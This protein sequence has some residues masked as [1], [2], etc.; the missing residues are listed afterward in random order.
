MPRYSKT[1]IKRLNTCHKDLQI[2]FYEVI[3]GFDCTILCGTRYEAEQNR[4]FG[5]G[6]SKTLYPNSKHNKIPALAVDACPSPIPAW[7]DIKSFSYFGGWVMS[8]AEKL[9]IGLR[10]GGD[11]DHD[12]N[13]NDQ[14]FNDYIH[15]E[16][17]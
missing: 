11:W 16:L 3:N 15:F 17:I 5:L 12:N 9:G 6:K 1:S 10:W 4:L 2:I 7:D 8:R 13:L 14:R